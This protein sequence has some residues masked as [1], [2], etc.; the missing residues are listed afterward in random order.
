LVTRILGP[1]GAE[2]AVPP[3]PPS[4]RVLGEAEAYMT[5]SLLMSVVDHGTAAAGR[6]VGRPVAGK[7][8]TS[9]QSKDAWFVGYSTDIVCATWTG[10]DDG[11]SLGAREQ[12]ATA[13]LPAW[14]NFMKAAEDK[15]P[16]TEFPRPSGIVSVRIDPKN[17]LRAYETED[18]A[19]DELFLSGT[20]PT[21]T[22]VPAVPGE[23]TGLNVSGED[24]GAPAAQAQGLVLPRADPPPF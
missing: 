3:R 21:E 2:I 6:N 12:G 9:N 22:S 20:E 4:R 8:G 24:G 16:A 17:G 7:T 13:A 23:Q 1:E 14:I 11:R 18:D 10:Y 5:T 19:M 15:R